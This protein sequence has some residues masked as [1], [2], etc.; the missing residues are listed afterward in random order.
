M[1]RIKTV[2]FLCVLIPV[3]LAGILFYAKNSQ[4][5][6]LDFYAAA[7]E[8]NIA[9][10]LVVALSL[11]ALLGLGAGVFAMIRLKREIR[12]LKRAAALKRA[13][14]E[15]QRPLPVLGSDAV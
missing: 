10:A 13:E 6:S 1:N 14:P 3:L 7:V 9:L 2:L 15:V 11:G 5:V 8:V 12:R 4:T